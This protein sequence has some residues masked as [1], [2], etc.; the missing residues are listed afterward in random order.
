VLADFVSGACEVHGRPTADVK[1]WDW[2]E[3]WGM[4]SS[5]FWEPIKAMGYG[6]Y[7]EFVQPYP[8][9]CDLFKLIDYSGHELVVATANP[10]HTGLAAS[11]AEWISTHLGR[12]ATITVASDG[13]TLRAPQLKALLA[14]PGRILI[15]DSDDNIEAFRD[16]GGEAITFPQ[17]WNKLHAMTPHRI[18]YVRDCLQLMKGAAA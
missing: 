2:Y 14:G 10:L 7:R 3:E 4:T 1:T 9:L 8:W 13:Q 15:D 18:E 12:V 11:K 16:A 17:P 5:Q 6:F